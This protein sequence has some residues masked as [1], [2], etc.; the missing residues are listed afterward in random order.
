MNSPCQVRSANSFATGYAANPMPSIGW[1]DL[2]RPEFPRY[3]QTLHKAE[4]YRHRLEHMARRCRSKAQAA[5][6]IFCATDES[7]LSIELPLVGGAF[8]HLRAK[9]R[10]T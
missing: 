6:A 9:K 1:R 5:C 10:P 7:G 3:E 2:F 4:D 8:P